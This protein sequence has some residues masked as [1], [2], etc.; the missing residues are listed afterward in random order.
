MNEFIF[1]IN[2]FLHYIVGGF[3]VYSILFPQKRIWPP[4]SKNSWQYRWYWNL[5]YIGVLLDVVLVFLEYDSWI[6][7]QKVRYF[8]GVPLILLGGYIVTKAIFTL[9]LK[10]TY[11]LKDGF[12]EEGLYKF[13]RNPQYLGDI[14]LILGLI[15]FLNSLNL[16][17]LLTVAMIIFILM[18]FSEEIWLEETYKQTYLDYKAKTSR[19]I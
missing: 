7:S 9:G 5:F 14:I 13:T 1:Y 4:P 2:L 12:V 17:V 15:L 8:I 3:V 11:G 19:F 18:P 6:I 10:N 16:T